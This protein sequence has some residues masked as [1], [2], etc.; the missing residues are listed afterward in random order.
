[1]GQ[2]FTSIH[3]TWIGILI[4]ERH[5]HTGPRRGLQNRL[6][7]AIVDTLSKSAPNIYVHWGAYE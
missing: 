1:M 5:Q 6:E 2:I 7:D 3:T 4:A